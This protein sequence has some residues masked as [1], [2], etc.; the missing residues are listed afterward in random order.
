VVLE[1]GIESFGVKCE[2]VENVTW[3]G[4]GSTDDRNFS[5]ISFSDKNSAPRA[6]LLPGNNSA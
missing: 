2:L 6:E 4:F 5:N 3:L 1:C